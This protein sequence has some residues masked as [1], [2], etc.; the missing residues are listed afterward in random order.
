LLRNSFIKGLLFLI[1]VM[2]F[3]AG[4]YN[5]FMLR[6][7]A[8][9]VYPAYSSLRSDPLGTKVFYESIDLLETHDAER[10]YRPLGR[11][12]LGSNTTVFFPGLSPSIGLFTI[13]SMMEDLNR[14]IQNRAR[15]VI[16]FQSYK[17]KQSQKKRKENESKQVSPP[18]IKKGKVDLKKSEDSKDKLSEN[19]IFQGIWVDFDDNYKESNAEPFPGVYEKKLIRPFSCRTDLFFEVDETWNIIYTR[20]GKPV[21]VE[22]NTEKGSI[23]FL[24]D[25][26]VLS[27]EAMRNERHPEFLA[28]LMGSSLNAVFDEFHLGIQENTGVAGLARKYRLHGL[29]FR[30]DSSGRTFYMEKFRCFCPSCTG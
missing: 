17:T 5:L 15:V 19:E 30:T 22:K 3:T 28:W 1:P 20:N 16:S 4:I 13:S 18:E 12:D 29:F 23:V 25:S 24:A 9:D 10:N 2:V 26:Y 11:L 14:I 7:K 6:F 21:V 27:N 8:G